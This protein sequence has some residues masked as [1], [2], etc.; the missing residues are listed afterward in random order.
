MTDTATRSESASKEVRVRSRRSLVSM[1]SSNRLLGVLVSI[2]LFLALWQLAS[3]IGWVNPNL[4]PPP[5]AVAERAARLIETGSLQQDLLA[6]LQRAGIGLAIGSAIGLVLGLLIGRVRA[7]DVFI[8]PLVQFFRNLSPTAMIPIAIIWFGIGE[9][10][11][12]FLVVWGT[13][14]FVTINTTAGV[15]STPESRL[16]AAACMGIGPLRQFVLVILPSSLPHIL[17]GLRLSVAS[18][19]LSLIPAEML[20]ADSGIGYMLQKSSIMGRTDDIFVALVVI[21]LLGFASD[22][23]LRLVWGAVLGRYTRH[24]S[25]S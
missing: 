21:A 2:G 23:L 20:A 18:A 1:L 19:F 24:L 12:Y 16:R 3:T 14:F 11:K 15:K 5:S 8:D 13:V 25:G 9:S 10:S 4:I 17:T 6:S 22:W 7:F